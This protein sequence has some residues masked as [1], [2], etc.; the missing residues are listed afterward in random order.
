MGT[1]SSDRVI[2]YVY[3]ALKAM[4]IVFSLTKMGLQLRELMIR[5]YTGGKWQ[6][7]EKVSVGEMHKPKVRGASAK[8]LK[9]CFCTVIC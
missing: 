4:E 1:L 5:M 3:L 9:R 8:S 2:Q 7:K 6:V